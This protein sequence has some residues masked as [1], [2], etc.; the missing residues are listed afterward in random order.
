VGNSQVINVVISESIDFL[1]S[2]ARATWVAT[3]KRRRN[4]L[5]AGACYMPQYYNGDSLSRRS[6]RISPLCLQVSCIFRSRT[7]T[8][9]HNSCSISAPCYQ[10]RIYTEPYSATRL[11]LFA[12]RFKVIL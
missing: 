12:P 9:C 5:S 3:V 11:L 10:F 8:A 2:E 1:I 4:L 6:R 7:V